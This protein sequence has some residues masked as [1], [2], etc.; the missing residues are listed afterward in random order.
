[1]Q[2]LN[3]YGEISI[4]ENLI[5]DACEK[6]ENDPMTQDSEERI[7][8]IRKNTIC[9][10]E[11]T[12]KTTSLVEKLAQDNFQRRVLASILRI[13]KDSL[14]PRD[15]TEEETRNALG[16][17]HRERTKLYT[18]IHFA[19]L[20]TYPASHGK[21]MNGGDALTI[22]EGI[23]T[24]GTSTLATRLMLITFSALS[25]TCGYLQQL[26]VDGEVSL[27][28]AIIQTTSIFLIVLLPYVHFGCFLDRRD[29]WKSRISDPSASDHCVNIL[30]S[31][32]FRPRVSHFQVACL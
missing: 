10:R 7:K 25:A 17:A 21:M 28:T 9:F 30:A 6:L 5:A 13:V 4:L 1:M 23:A 15:E 20:E 22:I 3:H 32:D 8:S 29:I 19:A 26:T 2:V 16:K 31:D 12:V 14:F 24:V 11:L 18:K 27:D